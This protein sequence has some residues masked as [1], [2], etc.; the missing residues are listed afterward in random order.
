MAVWSEVMVSTIRERRRFDADYY[1]PEYLRIERVLRSRSAWT[2]LGALARPLFSKGIFDI[3]A[4]EYVES[5][6]PFV[7]ITNLRDCTIDSNGMVYLT[8]ERSKKDIRTELAQYDI[9]LSK[10]AYPAASLVQL[11]IC[12]VSQ[13]IIAVKTNRDRKFNCFLVAFLNGRFGLPQMKRLFQGNI[14]SHLGLTEARQIVVPLPNEQFLTEIEQLFISAVLNRD[15]SDILYD[16]AQQILEKELGLNK[17]DF[18]HHVGYETC[19]TEI[20]RS[21]RWDAQHYRPKYGTLLNVILKAP[22]HELL[23]D[24]VMYNQR[25]LQPDYVPGGSVAVVNSQHIGPQHL[26]YDQF[27]RTSEDALISASRARILKNDVLVYTTGAYVGRTNVFLGDMP[28]LASNHVNTLR[29]RPGY[30]AAYIA[31]VMN[32]PVGLLQ[33]EKH[34]TG[35]TQAELYPSAIAKFLIP[36]LNLKTMTAIG[37]KV[38]ASYMALCE[39]KNPLEQAKRRVEEM[40]EQDGKR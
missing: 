13:D 30:D 36:I 8:P 29:L 19:L 10:T 6:V 26:A 23:R 40:I 22:D 2:T 34:A 16:S 12:N 25:G 20:F 7:R 17:I 1:R 9:V 32:S 11:P 35:S 21:R 33:T 4:E 5:G 28:A 24:I 37:D 27:E 14:Q 31:L 18:S 39:A 38:R 15:H 3:K